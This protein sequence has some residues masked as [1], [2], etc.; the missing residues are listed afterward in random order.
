MSSLFFYYFEFFFWAELKKPK[1]FQNQLAKALFKIF[2]ILLPARLWPVRRQPLA[3]HPSVTHPAAKIAPSRQKSFFLG[4]EFS[5]T[6]SKPRLHG[7]FWLMVNPATLRI[8]KIP[9]FFSMKVVE[10]FIGW[11]VFSALR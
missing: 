10:T 8:K 7:S 3:R 2:L 11:G 5:K 6:P 4:L 1:Y 9:A